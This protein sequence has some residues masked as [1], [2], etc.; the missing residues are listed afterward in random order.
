MSKRTETET[1]TERRLR[2][3]LGPW[4]RTVGEEVERDAGAEVADR[5]PPQ[6]RSPTLERGTDP[7]GPLERR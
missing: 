4:L 1:E 2:M 7:R 6:G 5:P 3:G